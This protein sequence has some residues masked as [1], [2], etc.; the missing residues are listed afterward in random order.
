MRV[1]LS[2][3]FLL[4]TAGSIIEHS[5]GS[6]IPLLG[7]LEAQIRNCQRSPYT[8]HKNTCPGKQMYPMLKEKLLEK[9]FKTPIQRLGHFYM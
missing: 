4:E 9:C 2:Q 3:R 8:R 6:G 7:G 1:I 5:G